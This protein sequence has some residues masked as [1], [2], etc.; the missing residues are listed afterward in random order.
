MLMLKAVHAVVRGEL[1][2]PDEIVQE[3]ALLN[4]GVGSM[5]TLTDRELEVLRLLAKGQSMSEIAE[6]TEV[7]YKT[8]ATDCASLREKLKA[9]TSTELVR[10]AMEQKII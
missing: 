3:L 6:V 5:P 4:V 8:I 9:R 2:L 7:S 1:W 10:L